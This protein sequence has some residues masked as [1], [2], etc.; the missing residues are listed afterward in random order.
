MGVWELGKFGLGHDRADLTQRE[1]YSQVLPDWKEEDVIG[2]PLCIVDY[3]VNHEIGNED[4]LQWLRSEFKRRDI[5]LMLDFVA[6]HTAVD[7]PEFGTNPNLYIKGRGDDRSRF[8]GEGVAF[9]A[10]QWISPMYFSAQLNMFN[11]ETRRIQIEKLKWVASRC[12]GVRVHVA[13][14]ALTE[15]FQRQ[16]AAE[17]DGYPV[18]E[19]EFWAEAI[20]EVRQ[21]YP[22][23]VLMAETYGRD[24]QQLLL[25]FGFDYVY[26]KELLDD[27]CHGSLDAFRSNMMRLTDRYVHFIENHDE[28]R[29]IAR[30]HDN[31]KKAMAAAAALLTLPGMR[32]VNFNQWLGYHNTIDV[33]LRRAPPETYR[34]ETFAFYKKLTELLGSDALK[35]GEWTPLE[36]SESETV[37]A[38]KWVKEQERFAI[39]VNFSSN[40]SGGFVRLDDAPTEQPKIAV[41]EFYSGEVYERDPVEMREV[42]L[43]LLLEPYQVQVLQY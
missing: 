14:F 28:V 41:T 5:R 11:P 27:L 39:V 19:R 22:K 36:V 26:D 4:D 32:L 6:D 35:Y 7:A 2:Y 30:F 31:E 3:K 16:W 8:L 43:T 21:E 37:L 42:G 9:A 38:W 1:R 20:A 15:L 17:L 40:G 29:A 12:D 25:N 18:P 34:S 33:H 13:H 10:G 23:F 24:I